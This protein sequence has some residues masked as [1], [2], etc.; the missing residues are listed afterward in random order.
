MPMVSATFPAGEVVESIPAPAMQIMCPE[1]WQW[2][3]SSKFLVFLKNSK[4][5]EN[6]V[7]QFHAELCKAEKTMCK[8][9]SET[10][11]GQSS[12]GGV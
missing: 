3:N 2:R 5:I 9:T 12:L 4:N 7:A 6:R 10:S 8:K 11:D 1:H